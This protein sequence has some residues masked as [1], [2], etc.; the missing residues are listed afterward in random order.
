[1]QGA[2]PQHLLSD[3]GDVRVESEIK[4]LRASGVSWLTIALNNLSTT[5][6]QG[7]NHYWHPPCYFLSQVF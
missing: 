2:L 6:K 5:F 3:T 4:V 7:C 1:M